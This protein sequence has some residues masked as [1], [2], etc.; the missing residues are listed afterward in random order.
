MREGGTL[1]ARSGRRRL[2]VASRAVR[3]GIIVLVHVY[4]VTVGAVLPNSCRFRPTC[5]E[6]AVEAVAKHG[7]LRG[8]WLAAKR[9]V[10]CNPL[11]SGGP[12]PV[13]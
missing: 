12:D 11:C 8:G 10:R 3:W 2:S 5:S 6:Y 7:A 4:R 13:P 9:V 1:E